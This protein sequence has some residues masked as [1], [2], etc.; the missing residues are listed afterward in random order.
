M[1]ILDSG[2][3]RCIYTYMDNTVNTAP[4]NGSPDIS[5]C[6][7]AN[8]RKTMRVVSQFYDAALKPCGLRATQFT[9]LAVLRRMGELPLTKLAEI[10]V[11]D[12]TTLTRNLKPLVEKNWVI[13]A[14]EK[15]ERIRLISITEVG[16]D[17]V[18]EAMPLWQNAQER[19]TKELGKPR[20]SGM[21]E[22]LAALGEAV[23]I[24]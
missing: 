6:A 14:R 13:I 20:L 9:L 1:I 15:D 10:L 5:V 22:D 21:I 7:H 16:R 3:V 8:L 4:S 17:I 18:G 24:R 2:L 19:V 12:R 23:R 11:M